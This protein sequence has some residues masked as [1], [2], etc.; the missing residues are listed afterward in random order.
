MINSQ[1]HTSGSAPDDAPDSIAAQPFSVGATLREARTRLG[2]NV[3]DVA[4]HIKFA[5]RQIEAL[6][7]DN[8]AHLPEMAFVRGFVRS[9]AK[10]LQLDPAPL[11]A[12]LPG[13]PAQ[14]APPATS[15]LEEIPFRRNDQY[16]LTQARYGY[17]TLCP[18]RS[19]QLDERKVS[20]FGLPHF[21]YCIG[22]V[23]AYRT[24]HLSA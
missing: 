9:Y 2:L 8:F 6:E 23:P 4:N 13:A 15:I 11:L 22:Q 19:R 1:P 24:C 20:L 7:E 10:L 21:G 5:P 16:I 3:A 18:R 14:P 12:A 17:Y